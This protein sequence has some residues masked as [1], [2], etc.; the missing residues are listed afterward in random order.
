MSFATNQDFGTEIASGSLFIFVLFELKTKK[1][2]TIEKKCQK[3]ALKINKI[4][5]A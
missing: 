4:Q 3:F 1:K 5:K 2:K